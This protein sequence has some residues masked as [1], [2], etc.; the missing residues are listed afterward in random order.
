M[1][2]VGNMSDD[3]NKTGMVSSLNTGGD[4]KHFGW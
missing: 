3:M 4:I 1:T 2:Y